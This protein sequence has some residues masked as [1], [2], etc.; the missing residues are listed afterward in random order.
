MTQNG[1]KQDRDMAQNRAAKRAKKQGAEPARFAGARRRDRQA[2][3]AS[4][5]LQATVV[6]L[7]SFPAGPGL[8]QQIAAT[9]R[10]Q[11]G[12]VVGGQ[13]S[14]G[15]SPAQTTVQQGSQRAAID[16]RSYDVGSG[17]TVLYQQPNAQAIVLNRVT[18]PDPSVIAGRIQ[19]NGQV[20]LVNGS[21]VVFTRGSQV[22]VQSLVVSSAG[23]TN[24][25]FMAGKMVFDQPGRPDARIS[26]AGRITVAE[27]GL[28]ALVAPQVANSGLIQAKMG[29]VVLAGAEAH[30]VDLYGDGL[31][32][33]DV[34]RQVT[35]APGGGTALVTNTGTVMADGGTILL[36]AKA[37][38]G[39]V[40]NLVSAK[41]KLQANSVGERTGTVMVSAVGGTISIEGAIQADGRAPGT[42]GGTV[43]L[44]ADNVA[45]QPA[46]RISANGR[47]GGGTVAVGTT[48][49]RAQA[50]GNPAAGFPAGTAQT[51]TIADGARISADGRG[52]GSGGTVAV[53]SSNRTVMAGRITARGGKNGGDGGRVEISGQQG[54]RIT[55]TVDTTAPKGKIGT[56]TIDPDTLVIG[57]NVATANPA[58]PNPD[59]TNQ[60]ATGA[61]TISAAT[62][63]AF[64]SNIN[65]Q[66]TNSIT[67]QGA[68]VLTGG[69]HTIILTGTGAA[70]TINVNVGINTIGSVALVGGAGAGGL[71]TVNAAVKGNG[72]TLSGN[73]VSFTST[74][75][76]DGGTRVALN[77]NTLTL[78]AG[79]TVTSTQTVAVAPLTAGTTLSIDAVKVAGRL[80]L[81]PADVAIL[82]PAGGPT[83]LVLGSTN[84]APSAA[85][86]TAGSINFNTPLAV[87]PATL[88]L[89]NTGDVTQGVLAVLNVNTL[90][91]DTSGAVVLNSAANV[92]S[93]LGGYTA[94][95][96]FALNTPSTAL[97]L[98]GALTSGPVDLTAA[99]LS[100]TAAGKVTASTFNSNTTGAVTL[101]VATNAIS[102]LG[103]VTA[104]G[105]FTLEN[106]GT[107][108][109]VTGTINLGTHTL[110]VNALSLTESGSGVITA[111]SLTGTFPNDVSLLANPNAITSLGSLSLGGNFLLNDGTV[112]LN[113]TNA[114]NASG[115]TIR[116]DAGSLSQ[117]AAGVITAATF[118]GSTTG[119]ANLSTAN[120]AIVNLG[121]FTNTS[122]DFSLKTTGSLNI[123]GTVDVT[124]H[125]LAF[126]TGGLTEGA[127]GTLKAST[128]TGSTTGTVALGQTNTIVNLG[129]FTNTSGDFAL[130]TGGSLNVS[131]TVDVTGHTLTLTTA[132]LTEGASG[133]L[134]ATT[135]AGSTTG[136][137]TLGRSNAI[138]NLG[139]FTNTSGDFSLTNT[140]VL[141]IAGTVDVTGHTL[142][143]NTGGL[144]EGASGLLKATTLAGSSTG[145]VTLNQTNTI[146][147][148]G[149][150]TNTAGDF[151]LTTGASLNISGT[152]DVT[153]HTLTLTTGG[154]TEGASGTLTAATLTG[155]TTGTVALNQANTITNL[156][157]F[158]NTSGDFSL[159]NGASALGLTGTV[160]AT[161]HTIAL[162]AGTLNLTGGS[163]GHL[164]ASRIE[165]RADAWSVTGAAVTSLPATGVLAL[166]PRT[167]GGFTI[168]SGAGNLTSANI[169]ALLPASS[170][171]TVQLGNTSTAPTA[172]NSQATTLTLTD[173]L[174]LTGRSANLALFSQGSIIESGAGAVT[175]ATLTGAS[176]G[177]VTLGGSNNVTNLG[178]FTNT[179]GDFSLTNTGVLN[180]AGT[181]DVTGHTLTLNTGG[182]TEGASGLLKATALAGSSTGTVTLG[183]TNTITNL[184]AFTNTAGDFALT[185][186]ASLNISGTVDVTGH[187]LTLTT[188]GL[189]EGASGTLTAAT[190]TG[191]T[192]GTVALNQA[193]TITNLG[194][195]TNTS[196]D[197]SLN[198]GA[199]ALGLTGTVDATGHTIALTAGT[200]NLTG[201]SGGHLTASRIEL[202][203]DAWSVTGAAVTS[204]PATGVLALAPRTVG[205]FTIG[206]GAGNLTSANILALLPASSIDTVQLGNTS[207][208]PTAANSQATTL[209]LTDALVLTGRSANLALF[210][211]GS[212]IESGA[213]AVT[214][215]T[216]TG[217]SGGTVTLGG[218]NNVTNLGAFTNTSGDFSL[219]NTGVLN[220]AGTV[221]V[222]G[223]TLT[224]NTGGLT[225]G[226]SG[227]LK[228]TT[229][230]G[231]STGTVTLNQTNTIT[232]L[233]AFTNTAGDF[234]LTTG[235]SLNISGT[236]DVTGHTLTLTTGGLTEGASGTLTAATLTGSTAGTV[237]LNQANTITNLGTFTNTSGDFSLNNT[238]NL[239]IAGTVDVTGHTLTLNTGGLTEGPSG[240]LKAATLTGGTSGTAT[241]DQTNTVAN[242]GTFTNTAGDFTLKTGGVLNVSGTVDVTGH[243][244]TL[245]TAGLTESALG[246]I[247]AGTLAGSTTGTVTLG[248]TNTIANLGTFTNTSGDFSLKT[249]NSLNIAGTVDITGHTLTL[250]TGGLTEGPLGLLK[251]DTLTGSTTGTVTLGQTNTIA[252]LGTFT[253]TAGDFL[254]TTGGIL[255]ISGT[256]DVTGHTLTLTTA[257][258]TEG[259]LGLL[260]ADTLAG[261]STGTVTLTQNNVVANLGTFTNTAGDFA[262]NTTGGLNVSGTVDVSGHTLTLTTGNTAGIGLSEGAAGL[263]KAD[264]LT[265]STTGSTT[266]TRN[267][268]LANLGTFTNTLGDFALNTTGGLNVSGTVDVSGHT[269]TLTTGNTAGIGLSEGA[270]GLI[271]ADTLS[272]S[273]TGSATLT[274]ANVVANLG[275][276]TNTAGDFALNTTGGLNVSGTVDVTSHTL[277]LTTGN[278]AGIGLSENAGTITAGTLTGSTTGTVTLDQTNAISNLGPFT[279]ISGDFT[280]NDGITALTIIGA[281]NAGI[282]TVTLTAGS[283]GQTA[284]GLITAGL[285]TGS[286]GSVDLPQGNVVT[287]LGQFTASA[288]DFTFTNAGALTV[289]GPVAA[290]AG[291]ATITVQA[292][293]MTVSPVALPALATITAKSVILAATDVIATGTVGACTV[294]GAGGDVTVTAGNT[295]TV[296]GSGVI[297]GQSSA[298]L[299]AA[300]IF[301]NGAGSLIDGPAVTLTGDFN[302][303]AG[304][305]IGGTVTLTGTLTQA[306]GTI[307]SGS[308]FS[309][310]APQIDGTIAS[311]GNITLTG[312]TSVTG[313]VQSDASVSIATPSTTSLALSGTVLAK[314][315]LTV[316]QGTKGVAGGNGGGITQTAGVLSAGRDVL[317][318]AADGAAAQS[319]GRL[320]GTRTV[321]VISMAADNSF[322]PSVQPVL[323]GS[324]GTPTTFLCPGCTGSADPGLPGTITGVLFTSRPATV[325][326]DGVTPDPGA[327]CRGRCGYPAFRRQHQRHRRSQRR[328]AERHRGIRVQRVRPQPA[329]P[330]TAR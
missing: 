9:A 119:T 276:F 153:G 206:S 4:T 300:T 1:N 220:I 260:K 273:T 200:L 173:A 137:V 30:T 272:G 290:A 229:L 141:N 142:T 88:G 171:D 180:I 12:T 320:A 55:G 289:A 19:A 274:Q 285:L 234:A 47:A 108:L 87:N 268:V 188:G 161:G 292:G 224:L 266:L 282:H 301:Q 132:G 280:L 182:L 230:A 113:L 258:L 123:S 201:G 68:T 11:G 110:N 91:G 183:Q 94:G 111:G 66:A 50:Q 3:L 53:L 189:T 116:L 216:L 303:S 104:G 143:L 155:S 2:L 146:T 184:G 177:T 269:L 106:T 187:T 10:P 192:A 196:G 307:W 64:A 195:F 40:Q 92:V 62:F 169:L 102:N 261:S 159:N 240:T 168:G 125:T 211:Q 205:G 98:T 214:V 118:T 124:G 317:I 69:N 8:A 318:Y 190:L 36:T 56:L 279:N 237:A 148:L 315:D 236:V 262:L 250:T 310:L 309:A 130:K 24:G 324:V 244:L 27:T 133:L 213:G 175:V 316:V 43:V 45:V 327:R 86:S 202:R 67:L 5:A 28:A 311:G 105:D 271:K 65:L 248:Q 150:F 267:N 117:T 38:D 72:V 16:W 247:N 305:T 7:L 129:T 80:S 293:T 151:A 270:A 263:I 156:G 115:H 226:A 253:N 227:L 139:A 44:N 96:S 174:V 208:A 249:G 140:G 186:G 81:T 306:G 323:T 218:S 73:S 209:T 199:S 241:L 89:F 99:S 71:V 330:H 95:T 34:T 52:N 13:A 288:G 25:N 163:G 32:S 165:L 321:Q 23:V 75:S 128:L 191:S 29:H 126:T 90:A 302:Q 264:T 157:A 26:N 54:L 120:N 60:P 198:N 212:I 170:I 286:A 325:R 291:T 70:A 61:Q 77:A 246:I 252:N 287:T 296:S 319:G 207:T 222:T 166:A 164:T 6:I 243:T 297:G 329:A 181:V 172:A 84:A 20:V 100:Q 167:V 239:N 158:T 147:N 204:L 79:S 33:V 101:N 162:T 217:A 277:T 131:G 122:G 103:N 152:V 51:V 48:A 35:R 112:A 109:G 275:T 39:I 144:T 219:T 22:D 136:T 145:T 57:D 255:N 97:Q 82:A 121:A 322:T 138:V 265:G 245:I 197:F 238:G 298:A 295:I 14:I 278:T 83:T 215:A 76:V 223:H 17:H 107:A 74:G 149:A 284:P 257:G 58:A 304:R 18:G 21:G 179:S 313:S 242:L 134:K 259:A 312:V 314:Q 63:N 78:A 127:S 59:G 294:A 232:N 160:D 231:S 256:V 210:S 228:A 135:L 308:G 46:A 42:R 203:A 154:L 93:N 193:N 233:G 15:Q 114:L 176:G 185:T 299:T 37:A 251:A 281:L 178:A 254:L 235:A 194:T 328:Y 85:N 225:E 31:M 49:A 221:D 283:I 41:G 326:L